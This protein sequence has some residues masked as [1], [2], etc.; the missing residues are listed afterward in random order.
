MISVTMTIGSLC[1]SSSLSV[2]I[3]QRDEYSNVLGE[4]LPLTDGIIFDLSSLY[5][6]V[7][8]PVDRR[9]QW[10]K[11]YA[12][13]G[14]QGPKSCVPGL[15]EHNITLFDLNKILTTAS[16]APA[17]GSS[18]GGWNWKLRLI[19]VQY[20]RCSTWGVAVVQF[21]HWVLSMRSTREGFVEAMLVTN[22]ITTKI[23]AIPVP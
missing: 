17:T 16:S 20:W 3:Q 11:V 21:Q 7:Q 1:C 10:R 23:F 13:K 22:M 9:L 14:D 2:S 8:R 6:P 15:M 5:H 12:S 19:E 4:E 18:Q